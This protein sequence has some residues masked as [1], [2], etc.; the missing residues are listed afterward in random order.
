MEPPAHDSWDEDRYEGG[1]KKIWAEIND[2]IRN[3]LRGMEAL[4]EDD[5]QDVA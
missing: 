1:E 3:E 2:F 5:A 4:M